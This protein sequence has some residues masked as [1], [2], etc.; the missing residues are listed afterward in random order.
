MRR[1][2]GVGAI[3]AILISPT[4]HAEVLDVG[5]HGFVSTHELALNASA[6]EAY[7]A[8]VEDVAKWWDGSHSFS[9]SAAGFSITDVAGGCLCERA[10]DVEVEHLR[11]VNVARGQTITFTGGLGPL[12]AMAVTGSM[13]FVFKPTETGST[14]TYRYSVGG[15]L[16]GGL[17]PLAEPVDR[18]QLG[19]L[20]RLQQY[21]ATGEALN[22]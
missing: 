18:V 1:F 11:V 10:G 3:M 7:T 16:P 21:L 15:Y 8:F 2:L 5:P 20:Q 13:T 12:Q 22:P 17:E 6:K 19:Q 9:G 4:V 14:L